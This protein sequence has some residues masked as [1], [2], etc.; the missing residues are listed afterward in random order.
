MVDHR[1][2]MWFA[3]FLKQVQNDAEHLPNFR[4]AITPVDA[5]RY[6][7]TTALWDVR[8]YD[9]FPPAGAGEMSWFLTRSGRLDSNS[10]GSRGS[11]YVN[12]D[13]SGSVRISDYLS[14]LPYPSQLE[15]WWYD[16]DTEDW[17]SDPFTQDTLIIGPAVADLWIDSS[18]DEFQVH[19]ALFEEPSGRYLQGGT[20]TVRNSN[21]FDRRVEIELGVT[22]M[23]IP[24]GSWLRLQVEN[25]AWHRPGGVG[26]GDSLH[27]LPVFED[28][29]FRVREGSQYG[30]N[31]TVPTVPLG[32]PTLIASEAALR[33]GAPNDVRLAVHSS[34]DHAGWTYEILG[35]TSGVFPGHLYSGA[36]IPVNYDW[37]TKRIQRSPN[38]LPISGFEGTLDSDGRAEAFVELSKLKIGIP[39]HINELDFAVLL[40][41][42]DGQTK[43]VSLPVAIPVPSY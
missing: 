35:S 33:R 5:T 9:T 25:L 42:P 4:F 3:H 43:E 41:S 22:G 14:Y 39:G 1:R 27:A 29:T 30:S 16:L 21:D 40:I 18:D 26:N 38:S 17:E 24:A 20:L 31:L 10:G 23:V 8:E 12:H 15:Q 7:D 6:D 34:S 11:S 13:E 36:D 32:D 28:F 19:A 37:L 2:N